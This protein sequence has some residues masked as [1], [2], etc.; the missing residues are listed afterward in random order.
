MQ[1]SRTHQGVTAFVRIGKLVW[2]FSS[3][4]KAMFAKFRD[5]AD[6]ADDQPGEIEQRP[7]VTGCRR[8]RSPFEGN[9]PADHFQL[10][11]ESE[12]VLQSPSAG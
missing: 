6:A 11:A 8:V 2:L 7:D 10:V 3:T 4:G 9:A 12:R 1:S 5:S